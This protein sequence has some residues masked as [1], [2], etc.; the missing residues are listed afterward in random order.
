MMATGD[1]N[2]ITGRLLSILP[3]SW[4]SSRA[5]ILTGLLQGFATAGSFVYGFIA[6]ARAQ[7]RLATMRGMF[8]DLFAF[9]FFGRYLWRKAAETDAALKVRIR[10]EIFRPRVTR[11]AMA[12]ALLDLTGNT[13]A[14]FEPWS[15]QDAGGYDAG[16]A[17]FDSAGGWGDTVLP[18]QVFIRLKRPGI[19]GVPNV[20]GFDA[21]AGGWDTGA[22]EYADASLMA[23]AVG[24]QDIYNAILATKPNGVTVWT[25][26]Q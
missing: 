14:I 1:Q 4:F 8:I 25:Q 23:G 18:A 15:P 5:P 10:K 13:P 16:G 11:A 6:T 9:D 24:D 21:G 26:L 12:Q 19:P 17:G 22:I 20:A 3:P 7:T 2:D